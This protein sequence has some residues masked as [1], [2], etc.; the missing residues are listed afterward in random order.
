MDVSHVDWVLVQL[1]ISESSFFPLSKFR[2]EINFVRVGVM[3][4]ILGASF[5]CPRQLG[6]PFLICR[7]LV[8]DVSCSVLPLGIMEFASVLDVMPFQDKR[9]LASSAVR[10]AS[11]GLFS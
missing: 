7:S 5:A 4:T 9:V 2:S 1:V 6:T 8:C 10:L 3:F 11:F